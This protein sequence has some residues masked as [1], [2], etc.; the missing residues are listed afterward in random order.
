MKVAMVEK[1]HVLL[2][3]EVPDPQIG[4][5]DVLCKML[6]G[7]TCTGTDQHIIAGRFPW[8]RVPRDLVE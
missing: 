4:E 8:Q 6:Y 1:A 3:R 2:V 7:A 5:Y